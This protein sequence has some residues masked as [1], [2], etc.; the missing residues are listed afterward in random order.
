MT[1][2][3][4]RSSRGAHAASAW[5]TARGQELGYFGN[6]VYTSSVHSRTAL[7]CIYRAKILRERLID[8]EV[9]DTAAERASNFSFA[10]VI[11]NTSYTYTVVAG[12][13]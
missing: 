5:Q 7:V 11:Y 1:T 3:A 10:N 2:K 12:S 4:P 9:F 13:D 6:S 8:W